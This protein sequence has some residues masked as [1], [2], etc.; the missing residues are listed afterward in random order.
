MLLG[1]QNFVTGNPPISNQSYG[2]FQTLLRVLVSKQA[3]FKKSLGG[4]FLDLILEFPSI[5]EI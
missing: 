3:K 2:I 5:F 4:Q 1:F